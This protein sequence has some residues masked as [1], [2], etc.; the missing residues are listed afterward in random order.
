MEDMKVKQ[1]IE[2]I[3]AKVVYVHIFNQ[4]RNFTETLL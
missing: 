3:Y 1:M 4:R 2:L